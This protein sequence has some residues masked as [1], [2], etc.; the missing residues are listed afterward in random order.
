MA[1]L[2]IVPHHQAEEVTLK[3][4]P[5]VNVSV[6]LRQRAASPKGSGVPAEAQVSGD[7]DKNPPTKGKLPPIILP[8]LTGTEHP[9]SETGGIA[10]KVSFYI[11]E[12][13]ADPQK[14]TTFF[15]NKDMPVNEHH[16]LI[17][18]IAHDEPI[19]LSAFT[20]FAASL[21]QKLEVVLVPKSENGE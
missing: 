13:G 14:L 2:R 9:F 4:S 16:Q 21:P 6:D 19:D 1:S 7:R 18:P 11:A 20:D 10:Q 5:T 15:K 17:V 3:V 8:L 12:P